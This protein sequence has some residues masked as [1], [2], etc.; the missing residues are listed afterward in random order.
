MFLFKR[1]LKLCINK[2]EL[3]HTPA[4]SVAP[5]LSTSLSD[6][7]DASN[8]VFFLHY[9]R[10]L[11]HFPGFKSHIQ[12][13]TLNVTEDIQFYLQHNCI[14]EETQWESEKMKRIRTAMHPALVIVYSR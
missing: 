13:G 12:W 1:K 8:L 4:A 14:V 2:G 5:L 7:S 6:P 9:F 3:C 10:A 11:I